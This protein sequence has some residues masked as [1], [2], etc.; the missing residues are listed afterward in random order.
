MEKI[1]KKEV[2]EFR[3]RNPFRTEQ[4]LAEYAEELEKSGYKPSTV[5]THINKIRVVC[6][7]LGSRFKGI[8]GIGVEDL[9]YVE[10]EMAT[11]D[12]ESR[13]HYLRWTSDI[14][15]SRTGRDPYSELRLL[16]DPGADVR[17]RYSAEFEAL[18]TNLEAR[19]LSDNMLTNAMSYA[20]GAWSEVLRA[21]PGI[22]L[23]NVD[24]THVAFLRATLP[25][26]YSSSV[27]SMLTYF[28]FLV[29]TVT[30]R[31]PMIEQRAD[32]G[33]MARRKTWF[34]DF[35]YGPLLKSYHDWMFEIGYRQTTIHNRMYG[36]I[37]A[38]KIINETLA[39]IEKMLHGVTKEFD[40][41]PEE[42]DCE[43]L[44]KVK[45]HQTSVRQNTIHE[46]FI[47]LSGFLKFLFNKPIVYDIPMCWQEDYKHAYFLDDAQWK[48]LVSNATE[49]DLI[50]LM[51]GG[52]L[53]LR[54]AEMANIKMKDI[55]AFDMTI[56]GKGHTAQGKVVEFP[57]NEIIECHIDRYKKY[58][59]GIIAK[60]GDHSNGFLI[61]HPEGPHAGHEMTPEQLG[62]YMTRLS[63]RTRIPFHTHM[64]RRLYAMD[65]MEETNGNI[66]ETS[67]LMRHERIDTTMKHYI[68]KN[69]STTFEKRDRANSKRSEMTERLLLERQLDNRKSEKR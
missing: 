30:G 31:N 59:K 32:R 62:N 28:S 64:L 37:Y 38:F 41:T 68:N 54:R 7:V 55:R 57:M 47:C 13:Y 43:M 49:T 23:D 50:I 56:H 6:S 14:V 20:A 60:F 10:D 39:R 65:M 21:Y 51:L 46:W 53:G 12:S 58:R 48:T 4:T 33:D 26:H 22:T 5:R 52:L 8:D 35:K 27:K 69:S 29:E 45:N 40:V 15:M 36:V 16:R 63:R 34:E 9:A 3:N 2:K 61:I 67:V 11:F 18:H 19:G 17:K 24:A 25:E 44:L 66:I 42:I 1:S